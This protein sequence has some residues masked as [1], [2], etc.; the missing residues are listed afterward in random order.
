MVRQSGRRRPTAHLTSSVRTFLESPGR[1]AVI[2]TV[3]GNGRPH[4]A[5]V[6][7]EVRNE[8]LLV[9]GSVGR[10]WVRAARREGWL[11]VAVADAYDHVIV[12]GPITVIVERERAM[13]DI[14]ALALR[15]GEQPG[16][17]A[18]QTRVTL[19]VHPERIAVHGALAAP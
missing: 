10:A 15:Y 16:D 19:L 5:V 6:W 12:S 2:S 11:S 7:Y 3:S 18:G 1:F 4:Q 8:E 9:N 13:D 17:F 14:K